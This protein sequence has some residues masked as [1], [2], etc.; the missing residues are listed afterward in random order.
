MK[1]EISIRSLRGALGSLVLH[2][3]AVGVLAPVAP[4]VAGL[5]RLT[6]PISQT[7]G[8][9]TRDIRE[10]QIAEASGLLI[11]TTRQGGVPPAEAGAI[12]LLIR[13][14]RQGILHRAD[15]RAE[16]AAIALLIRAARRRQGVARP[17]APHED[18]LAVEAAW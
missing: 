1:P 13:T 2:H 12:A 18:P 5:G 11:R 6:I 7:P 10:D 9:G 16:G 17:G 3:L 8:P 15:T 14:T 4:P